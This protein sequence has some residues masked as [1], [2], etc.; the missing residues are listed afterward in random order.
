MKP[1]VPVAWG[2]GIG[3]LFAYGQ[4]GSGKTFTVTQL[5]HLVA[6]ALLGDQLQ[7]ERR[8]YLAAFEL[9]GNS[10][11]GRSI[12]NVIL[13]MK[14]IVADLLNGRRPFSILEDSFGVTQLAGAV[15]ENVTTVDHV[16][17]L[18]EGAAKFR[19][20]EATEKNDSSSRSHAICRIRIENPSAP[21]AEDGMLYLVDLA[22]SEAA[23][24]KAKHGA[25]RM[26]ET[27]EINTSLSVL[28]D[29]IRGRAEAD[30]LLVAGTKKKPY[31]PFR[32]SAL[33]RVLKHVF[34]PKSMRTCKTVTVACVNPSLLDIGPSKNTLRYAEMLR[35]PVPEKKAVVHDPEA[36]LTWNNTQVKEW[37]GSNVSQYVIYRKLRSG[38][39]TNSML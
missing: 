39:T 13:Q 28:K 19:R 15:E 18:V 11:Y 31:I 3:T 35:V 24:D 21:E 25:E 22:G 20:T 16:L 27:R 23:R 14:L 29:C 30:A 17:G 33:T 7:D 32:Q 9:A 37:I 5:Q 1:L 2:G 4:T 8:V 6:Q 38:H 34:D 10:S 26:K 36:P 12:Y